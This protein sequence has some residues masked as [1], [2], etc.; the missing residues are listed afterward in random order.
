MPAAV[1]RVPPNARRGGMTL[2]N[3]FNKNKK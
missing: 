2:D 1:G 3:K